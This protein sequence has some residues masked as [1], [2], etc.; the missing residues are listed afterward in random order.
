MEKT[1]SEMEDQRITDAAQIRRLKEEFE[2]MQQEYLKQIDGISESYTKRT[3]VN[4]RTISELEAT[5]TSQAKRIK[6]LET[7]K[8]CRSVGSQAGNTYTQEVADREAREKKIINDYEKKLSLKS[9]EQETLIKKHQDD[10]EKLRKYHEDEVKCYK[11]MKTLQDVIDTTPVISEREIQLSIENGKLKKQVIE[12]MVRVDKEHWRNQ[13]LLEDFRK[14]DAKKED[15]QKEIEK[16]NRTIE[17]MKTEYSALKENRDESLRYLENCQR[18][19]VALGAHLQEKQKTIVELNNKLNENQ[20]THHKTLKHVK[21]LE[22]KV[23]EHLET[24]K[25]LERTDTVSRPTLKKLNDQFKQQKKKERVFKEDLLAC[26][27][28]ISDYRKLKDNLMALKR[29]HIDNEV[30]IVVDKK[31]RTEFEN[32]IALLNTCKI[33]VEKSAKKYKKE[34]EKEITACHHK[35]DKLHQDYNN[36]RMELMEYRRTGNEKKT[37]TVTITPNKQRAIDW[38]GRKSNKIATALVPVDI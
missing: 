22:L 7:L 26:M 16:L 36:T 38:L 31:T 12:A 27:E 4:E 20:S 8:K 2:E 23:S 21:D 25:L 10:I 37:Q 18:R 6:Y 11:T 32:S 5:V 35:Y 28:H 9:R 3:H 34:K 15:F 30:N 19:N 1:L 29:R 14:E 17:R 24:I 13:L 33:E